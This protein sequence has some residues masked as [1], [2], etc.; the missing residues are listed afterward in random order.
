LTIFN[1]DYWYEPTL[2]GAK[3]RGGQNRVYVPYIV[4]HGRQG[5]NNTPSG[6]LSNPRPYYFLFWNP[7]GNID[8]NQVRIPANFLKVPRTV[9]YPKP[10][11]GDTA[12]R[13]PVELPYNR[14]QLWNGVP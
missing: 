10:P 12:G 13:V 5:E 2:T 11:Q 3:N 4:D 6:S 14:S 7:V 9:V 1:T 8:L